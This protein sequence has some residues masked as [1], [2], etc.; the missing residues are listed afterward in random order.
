MPIC[1]EE[2]EVLAGTVIVIVV[3]L[4]AFPVS[5]DSVAFEVLAVQGLS[6]TTVQVVVPPAAGMTLLSFLVTE[7]AT[8]V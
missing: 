3:P 8:G 6:E 1:L 4:V 7:K 5:G 2:V